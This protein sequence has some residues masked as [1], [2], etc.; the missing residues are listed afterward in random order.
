MG[1]GGRGPTFCP[2][3]FSFVNNVFRMVLRALLLKIYFLR[4]LMTSPITSATVKRSNSSLHFVKSGF[5]STM[6]EDRFN[7]LL[8]LFIHKDLALD[9]DAIIDEYAKHNQRRMTFIIP[10]Q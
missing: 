1:R 4:L 8:L 10:L 2:G 3:I 9:Y 5:R 6:R 7:A